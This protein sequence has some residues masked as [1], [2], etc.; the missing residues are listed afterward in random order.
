MTTRGYSEEA[1]YSIL[2]PYARAWGIGVIVRTF[3]PVRRYF[4]QGRP[5]DNGPGEGDIVDWADKTTIWWRQTT[6]QIFLSRE[7]PYFL[8]ELGHCVG[9]EAPEYVED[10]LEYITGFEILSIRALGL[11]MEHWEDWQ[12]NFM[13]DNG[14]WSDQPEKWRR[15]IIKASMKKATEMGLFDKFGW[16]T[17]KRMERK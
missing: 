3:E 2:V 1:P 8:H 11:P 16:P 5:I 9:D 4:N 15:K 14:R 6:S 10:E 12:R 13:T 7:W 17:F